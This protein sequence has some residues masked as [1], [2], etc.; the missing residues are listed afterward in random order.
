MSAIE[1][2]LRQIHFPAFIKYVTRVN[3]YIGPETNP[4]K[5]NAAFCQFVIM[6]SLKHAVS[7]ATVSKAWGV[8]SMFFSLSRYGHVIMFLLCHYVM[9]FRLVT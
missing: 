7:P 8:F 2:S 1:I 6:P 9:L 3:G 4:C 5:I